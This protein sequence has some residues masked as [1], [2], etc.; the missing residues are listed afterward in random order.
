MRTFLSASYQL[1]SLFDIVGTDTTENNNLDE[2][3]KIYKQI[4]LSYMENEKDHVKDS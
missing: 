2:V 1:Q 4:Y 3:D